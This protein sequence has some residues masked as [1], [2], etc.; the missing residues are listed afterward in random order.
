M[1]LKQACQACLSSQT[2]GWV[3]RACYS[4]PQHLLLIFVLLYSLFM[5][6]LCCL[7][8]FIN[9][10]TSLQYCSIENP[11][12]RAFFPPRQKPCGKQGIKRLPYTLHSQYVQSKVSALQLQLAISSLFSL[13]RATHVTRAFIR[14]SDCLFAL[15]SY[16]VTPFAQASER[17]IVSQRGNRRSDP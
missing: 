1:C 11:G 9:D 2:A 14:W 16:A 10:T 6:I 3:S 4:Q 13:T 15:S 7:T 17:T 8:C 5:R 12:A